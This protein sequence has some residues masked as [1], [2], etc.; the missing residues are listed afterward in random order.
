MTYPEY[1][2]SEQWATLRAAAIRRDVQVLANIARAISDAWLI[3]AGQ[4]DDE[5]V[6]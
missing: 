3:G 1:L 4:L 2:E 6:T 5:V